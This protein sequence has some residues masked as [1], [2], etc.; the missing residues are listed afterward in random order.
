MDRM[1][2]VEIHCP[3]FSEPVPPEVLAFLSEADRRVEAFIDGHLDRPLPAFVPSD[4]EKVF[5]VLRWIREEQLAP[6]PRFC[7]WGS[8]LGIAA[9]LA[10]MLG[11]RAHG[12][13]IQPDLVRE[14][15]RLAADFAQRV[16]F[17]CGSLLPVGGEHYADLVEDFAWLDTGGQD[18]YDLL[19]FDPEDFDVIYAYPWPGEENV[20]EDLF[21]E[22]AADGSLF[23][24][25]HGREGLKVRRRVARRRH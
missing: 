7:E 1:S 13:E 22:Y 17:V 23:V 15:E 25:F 9:T 6:G 4:H 11:F 19:G 10:A 5:P 14:A 3:A 8:G 2:L 24:T 16:D 21:E 20:L 18:A 12:I